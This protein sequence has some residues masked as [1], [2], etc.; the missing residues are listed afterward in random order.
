MAKPKMELSRV[1]QVLDM[2]GIDAEDQKRVV[3]YAKEHQL[4]AGE[5]AVAMGADPQIAFRNRNGYKITGEMVQEV[6]AEQ[7]F[8][9]ARAAE[10]DIDT[11]AAT[12]GD[13]EK[14]PEAPKWLKANWGNNGV[15]KAVENPTVVDG[16]ASAA[17]IAQNIVM[18]SY[19]NPEIA[20]NEKVAAGVKAAATLTKGLLG[21][22]R[23]DGEQTGKLVAAAQEGLREAVRA[24]GV[25]PVDN[26]G[27]EI[28][29]ESYIAERTQEIE[30]GVKQRLKAQEAAA[31]VG[32]VTPGPSTEF[33]NLPGP[34]G[35]YSNRGR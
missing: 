3:D 17:N 34:T 32:F 31:K 21:K 9:K 5:A 27:K 11:L 20:Q 19:D 23:L 30:A 1:K 33:A 28:D 2:L 18:S 7:V 6:L 4:F 13:Q 26:K 25:A 15:S 14:K 16:A 12:A 22:S 10:V 8:A 35:A 29:L 24:S